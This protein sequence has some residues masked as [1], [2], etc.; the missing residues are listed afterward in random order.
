LRQCEFEFAAM[1]A[2]EETAQGQD[3][4]DYG[5]SMQPVERTLRTG[6]GSFRLVSS[7]GCAG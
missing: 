4:P 1:G 2:R 6:I 7:G 5:W 3:Q